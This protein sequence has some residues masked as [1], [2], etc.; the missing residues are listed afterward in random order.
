MPPAVVT[1]GAW[2]SA[3]RGRWYGDLVFQKCL[4]HGRYQVSE[5]D[6]PIDICLALASTGRDGGD[7]VRRLSEFQER[8]ETQSFLK[9]VDVL[10]LQ[11]LN[12]SLVL[13]KHST[14]YTT[15]ESCTM[16][17]RYL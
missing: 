11:V 4:G 1:R 14:T 8:L 9:R 3:K 7:R 12:L 5:S 15:V 16:Q 17:N 13:K 6:T 2:R 10:A